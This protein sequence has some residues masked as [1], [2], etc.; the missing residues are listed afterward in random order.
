MFFLFEITKTSYAIIILV[1][2]YINVFKTVMRI[3]PGRRLQVFQLIISYTISNIIKLL[4]PIATAGIIS[5]VTRASNFNAIWFYVIL[6]I[7]KPGWFAIIIPL[8]SIYFL[9]ILRKT[10]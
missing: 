8:L 2:T 7:W 6:I 9:T 10:L 3:A 4:P 1:K 5:V